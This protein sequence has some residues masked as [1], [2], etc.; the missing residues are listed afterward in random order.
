MFSVWCL[1][2]VELWE[3]LEVHAVVGLGLDCDLRTGIKGNG[4]EDEDL[5]IIIMGGLD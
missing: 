2:E 5:R 1:L 4:I 3:E